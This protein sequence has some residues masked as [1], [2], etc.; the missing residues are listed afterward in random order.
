M[1]CTHR[2]MFAQQVL[3]EPCCELHHC[4][5]LPPSCA[6]ILFGWSQTPTTICQYTFPALLELGQHSPDS[7]VAGISVK[8]EIT[9]VHRVTQNR[10]SGE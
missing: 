7:K 10:G 1:V 5:Q 4:Q 6:V 2:E 3:T 8:N 9:T